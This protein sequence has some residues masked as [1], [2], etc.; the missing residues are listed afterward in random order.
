MITSVTPAYPSEAERLGIEANVELN[1]IVNAAGNVTG[2]ESSGFGAKIHRDDQNVAERA[3]FV[4]TQGNTFRDAAVAAARQWKFEP[5]SAQ[6]MCV[7]S[8]R[9]RLKPLDSKQAEKGADASIG[10]PILSATSS[11]TRPGETPSPPRTGVRVGGDIK[12]PRKI[13]DVKP[14]YPDDARAAKAKGVVLLEVII[15]ANGSVSNVRVLR[16]IPEFDQAA[17]D[18]VQQWKFEPTLLNGAQGEVEMLVYVNFVPA[19]ADR[20]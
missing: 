1:V 19:I 10:S 7:F 6:W 5:G 14:L 4:A 13:V 15:A 9:F 20:P 2:A 3:E 18:A 16:S 8:F 12:A 17:I 11:S